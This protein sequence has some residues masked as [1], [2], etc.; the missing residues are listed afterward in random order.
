MSNKYENIFRDK[1]ATEA[2]IRYMAIL[3]NDCYFNSGQRRDYLMSRYNVKATDELTT[4]QA[5]LV[6]SDLICRK[7]QTKLE[8]KSEDEE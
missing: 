6:I 7:S 1:L 2:Q 4:K 5:S 8:L 3:F